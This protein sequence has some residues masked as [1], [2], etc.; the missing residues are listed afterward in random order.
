MSSETIKKRKE[1]LNLIHYIEDNGDK[2]IPC[3]TCRRRNRKCVVA[4]DRSDRCSEC[5]RA[6]VP[7]NVKA[8]LADMWEDEV[9]SMTDWESIEKQEEK[10]REQEEEAMSKILRLRKQ[11]RLLCQR[12]DEM[13]K[14][15]LKF[16]DELD[17]AEEKERKEKELAQAA[18]TTDTSVPTVEPI[19]DPDL[20]AALG[21][22]DPSD[23]FWVTLDFDGETP[24]AS[25]GT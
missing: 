20:A 23:P 14:R 22:Y 13:A 3:S 24:Q 8:S 18:Q 16:L 1:R 12:R 5:I 25:Q 17:A 6:K 11:Q 21:A 7:C 15:G 4:P 10:L 2:M 19:L 9:P